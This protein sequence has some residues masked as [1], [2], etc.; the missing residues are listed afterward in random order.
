ME[1]S[2]VHRVKRDRPEIGHDS[3]KENINFKQQYK[4]SSFCDLE[5]VKR[6][7]LDYD[8][9]PKSKV[10]SEGA[11]SFAPKFLIQNILLLDHG[12]EFVLELGYANS[13]EKYTLS[14]KGRW[15]E[16][17]VYKVGQFISLQPSEKLLKENFEVIDNS[18]DKILILHPD[19]LV[20]ATTLASSINC[21]R[22]TILSELF[23]KTQ[24]AKP[25]LL[26]NILHQ[27]F[28]TA[29]KEQ[30]FTRKFFI[31]TYNKLCA[32]L[33]YLE[34]FYA[35]NIAPGDLQKDVEGY[36]SS[37]AKVGATLCGK[38]PNKSLNDSHINA[39]VCEEI[40]SNVW[41]P[42]LGMKGK[43][44]LLAK[45]LETSQNFVLELKTGKESNSIEHQD[46][47]R[48]YLKMLP[49][50]KQSL[51]FLIYLKSGSIIPIEQKGVSIK[52]LAIIR[53][54]LVFH[55]SQ[56]CEECQPG[57]EVGSDLPDLE[58]SAYNCRF[59]DQ[60]F[61]CGLTSK[62]IQGKRPNL[63]ELHADTENYSEAHEKFFIKWYKLCLTEYPISTTPSYSQIWRQSYSQRVKLGLTEGELSLDHQITE[64]T[65]KSGEGF[66]IRFKNAVG[67]PIRNIMVE[68][69]V[70]VSS[71]CL[72]IINVCS[73]SVVKVDKCSVEIITEQLIE[74]KKLTS[75]NLWRLDKTEIGSGSTLGLMLSNLSMFMSQS[76]P[77]VIKVRSLI[78]D[79]ELPKFADTDKNLIP[80]DMRDQA[81]DILKGLNACQKLAVR[82]VLMSSD[83]TII[84][85]MP[86]SGKTTVIVAVI[87]LLILCGH[88]VL[89]TSFTN[90]AVD[91]VMLKL[92]K[93]GSNIKMVRL[94]LKSRVHSSLHSY[95]SGAN[96][97]EYS[98]ITYQFDSADVVAG[99]VFNVN[100][101][102]F[103]GM[104][105]AFN[106]CIVDEASQLLLPLSIGPILAAQRFVL[107]GDEHQLPP[108]VSNEKA[109][110]GGLSESL[111]QM[112][113]S[114]NSKAVFSLNE[115]Y[116]MNQDIMQLSNTLSYN[117]QMKAGSSN[118]AQ[119][120]LSIEP[121]P[122]CAKECCKWLNFCLDPDN[123]AIFVDTNGLQGERS[124]NNSFSNCAELNV[125]STLLR[126]L[127][128][129]GVPMSSVGMIC[130]YRQQLMEAQS[131]LCVQNFEGLEV[132]T[133]DKFQGR[134]K[135]VI[136]MTC[137]KSSRKVE[138]VRKEELLNDKQRVNV[139]MSRAKSKLIIVGDVITMKF[140]QPMGVIIDVIQSKSCLIRF[141]EHSQSD[142]SDNGAK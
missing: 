98:K 111:F 102:V 26:G 64:N 9:D 68:D 137:V 120:R 97:L 35:L 2:R 42:F 82:K 104:K 74:E 130:P 123:S 88:R 142:G 45:T 117:G 6:Q 36:I 105:R 138:N 79:A 125:I 141:T 83:Y 71:Q 39:L 106:F 52:E 121:N 92:Q 22:K 127:K 40:E 58:E 14:V 116:R 100:H 11:H 56:L 19:F 107:V 25:M 38:I 12:K 78:V 114:R 63:E 93:I 51:G 113:A 4:C 10:P 69:R 59:C 46:Q 3:D 47:V 44:D 13:A 5:S 109:K 140:Y 60:R 94:G 77:R 50:V 18:D 1:P 128:R 17:N 99:T 53:N 27:L 72:N 65:N 55:F 135:E 49:S 62:L 81:K 115:Q 90:A 23:K 112:I 87:R 66:L 31:E 108:L 136:L 61:N 34:P 41:A 96:G 133:V 103:N 131:K 21:K 67:V 43:I 139:A 95:L 8:D 89:L 32:N 134:D 57:K 37:M 33:S 30:N 7:R 85:G 80:T 28:S 86:G 48:L 101:P 124:R 91:N 70:I 75:G 15:C 76:I 54:K 126:A 84:R 110:A 29:F 118:V 119:R 122:N 24:Y 129:C 16:E 132:H 73:G 20:S